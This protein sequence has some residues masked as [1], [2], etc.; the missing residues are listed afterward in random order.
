MRCCVSRSPL[1]G[2]FSESSGLGGSP[3]FFSPRLNDIMNSAH[4]FLPRDSKGSSVRER[5]GE[6]EPTKPHGK[7]SRAAVGARRRLLLPMV[8]SVKSEKRYA[9]TGHIPGHPPPAR[10]IAKT[11]RPTVYAGAAAL[12]GA[13]SREQLGCV[14]DSER[15]ARERPPRPPGAPTDPRRRPA[16]AVARSGR[17]RAHQSR[18]GSGVVECLPTRSQPFEP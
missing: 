14:K 5:P 8:Y 2:R 15:A 9:A 10:R 16:H 17:T 4:F 13:G 6:A 11:T 12:S 3:L 7:C 18:L 1:R